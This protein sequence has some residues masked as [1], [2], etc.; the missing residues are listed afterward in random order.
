M[1]VCGHCW[2][3]GYKFDC[4]EGERVE[5]ECGLCEGKHKVCKACH[6]AIELEDFADVAHSLLALM[7]QRRSSRARALL[8]DGGELY[9]DG[10]RGGGKGTCL[11]E[12]VSALVVAPFGDVV[13]CDSC[14]RL[15]ANRSAAAAEGAQ[16]REL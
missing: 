2:V 1:A 9:I 12:N 16:R 14:R 8:A 3:C 11:H 5:F 4:V 7:V 10:G 6:D 13:V 15:F